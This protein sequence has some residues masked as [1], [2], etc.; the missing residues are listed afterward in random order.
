[1]AT[2][3]GWT[4]RTRAIALTV[5]VAVILGALA[6]IAAITAAENREGLRVI[7][8]KTGPMRVAGQSLQSALLDQ[9]T[10]VRGFVLTS[11]DEDLKPYQE[12]LDDEQRLIG[13]IR[14]L[15]G[16]S[17]EDAAVRQQLEA[18]DAGSQA[19]RATI[20]EPVIAAVRAGDG[21]Q[22]QQIIDQGSRQRFDVLRA[23]LDK[24]Q[25][26]I[27]TLRNVFAERTQSTANLLIF[28]LVLAAAVII[29]A[30]AALLVLLERF[31]IKPV[32]DLAAEARLVAAG[33][34]QHKISGSGVPEL[35]ALAADIDGMRRKIAADLAEVI[36]ARAAIE[37]TNKQLEEQHE[38]LT[39]SNRDL[40][41]FAYVASHDLQEPLRKVASFCQLLQRRYGGKLDERADQYIYF[42]VDG[43]QRMQRLINDLLAFSRIGRITA[44]FTEVDLDKVMDEVSGQLDAA[45]EYADGEIVYTDLPTIRGEEP[46]LT[47]LLANLVN[48]ALKFRK[49][50]LPPRVEIRARQVGDQWEISCEDNG[51][52]IEAEFADKVFVIFQRL[53]AKDAYPGTGIGLAIAK[54]IV[55]YHGGRIWIDSD[56]TGG[57]AIRFTLPVIASEAAELPSDQGTPQ[58]QEENA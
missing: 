55:E 28:L 18:V 31:V 39:R 15:L 14:G 33:D 2:G 44:G 49:P 43:A 54:K 16:D 26:D 51:I 50:E 40:E 22:A 24:L 38:E 47:N 20:A 7:L 23:D 34:Y 27:F 13:E 37:A 17:A 9:E 19:W 3:K 53:H 46:L 30:G 42:A 12:G 10:A 57:T 6:A 41:Q 21:A 56:Y 52:G 4:L 1:M 11:D 45:R 8:E 25:E 48:N 36:A 58:L 32:T 35:A 5:V 29:V